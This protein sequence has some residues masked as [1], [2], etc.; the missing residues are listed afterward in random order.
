MCEKKR[1]KKMGKKITAA[2][3]KETL[4]QMLVSVVL[5]AIAAFVVL[6]MSPSDAVIK[7]IVLAIYAVSAFVGGFLMGKVMDRRK[8][9]WGLVAGA[10]YITVIL[11]VAFVVKGN[12][13][14][15]M[16]GVTSGIIASLAGG[17][18]GGMLS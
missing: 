3:L 8:F 7:V 6:K 1:S 15:G 2:I 4:I 5:I 18:I 14:A 12:F 17:T 10:V 16:V 11:L 13:N 9:L